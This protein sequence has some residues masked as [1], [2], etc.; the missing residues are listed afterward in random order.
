VAAVE[1]DLRWLLD[2]AAIE[3]VL[4]RYSRAL[5]REDWALLRSCYHPDGIDDHGRFRGDVEGLI[6]WLKDDNGGYLATT[7]FL[8]NTL[9]EIEADVAWAETYCVATHRQPPAVDGGPAWDVVNRVRYWDRFER[10]EGEWRIAHRVVVRDPGREDP[11][12]SEAPPHP[13]STMGRRGGDDPTYRR[14]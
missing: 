14:S 6:E 13:G 7:H 1:R 11:V 5:D 12:V 9:I 2:R 8:G 4:Y 3:D 10:R